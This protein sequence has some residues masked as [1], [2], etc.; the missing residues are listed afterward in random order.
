MILNTF[1][2]GFTS[3][4]AAHVSGV[5]SLLKG[6]NSDLWNDDIAYI[7]RLSADD[8]GDPGWDS[9]YGWGRINAYEAL[10]M[11]AMPNYVMH[12]ETGNGSVYSSSQ[13]TFYLC[14]VPN[15]AD[16]PYAGYSREIRKDVTFAHPFDTVL[17]AWGRGPASNGYIP[18]GLNFGWLYSDIV[19]GS[20]T[21]AGMTVRTYVFE[22]WDF[23]GDYVGYVPCTPSEATM[24]YTVVG[25]PSCYRICG[26]ANGDYLVNI[27]DAVYLIDYVMIGGDP[28][29]PLACGDANGDETVNVSDVVKI[30]N[31]VFVGGDPPGDCSPGSPNWIDG[32]CCPFEE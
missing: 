26:D 4:A 21:N 14:G 28:P 25:V 23:G 22:L 15:L 11:I 17:G 1:D 29:V 32:D 8:K 3:A 6:Y 27:Q 9:L 31:Y 19:E 24:A 5:A 13:R 12:D 16:G 7:L 10:K 30:I 18:Y 2:F 20:V